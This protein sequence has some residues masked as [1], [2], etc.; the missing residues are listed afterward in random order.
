MWSD[1]DK[2]F[3]TWMHRYGYKVVDKE[4]LRILRADY[5]NGVIKTFEEYIERL[6]RYL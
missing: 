2:E 1:K 6:N 5:D 4:I 3:N